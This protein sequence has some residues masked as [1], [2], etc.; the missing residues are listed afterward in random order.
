MVKHRFPADEN[1]ISWQGQK[2][3]QKTPEQKWAVSPR[4][5]R[6]ER[7]VKRHDQAGRSAEGGGF[8]WAD[9]LQNSTMLQI[10]LIH[11]VRAHSHARSA[12]VPAK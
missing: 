12:Q 7:S 8:C 3:V 4:W 10:A 6:C 2:V 5:T 1:I 9:V 11:G